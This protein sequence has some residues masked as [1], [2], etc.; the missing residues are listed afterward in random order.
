[1]VETIFSDMRDLGFKAETREDGSI[2]VES[3]KGESTKLSPEQVEQ[4]TEVAEAGDGQQS[5]GGGLV[6]RPAPNP[7][8]HVAIGHEGMSEERSPFGM[9]LDGH[10]VSITEDV[11]ED[12][13]EAVG[14]EA[15]A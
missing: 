10:I 7:D 5:I 15:E 9:R 4:A 1:M 3:A 11:W 8:F 12:I 6:A 13:Q 14:A 2:Y